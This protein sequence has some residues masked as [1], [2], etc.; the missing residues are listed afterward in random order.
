MK[1]R[2]T[3]FAF[4][5]LKPLN[6][7]SLLFPPHSAY[8]DYRC[9]THLYSTSRCS[10]PLLSREVK[11]ENK[12]SKEILKDLKNILRSCIVNTS[13]GWNVRRW[14]EICYIILKVKTQT[15]FIKLL[16]T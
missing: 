14:G 16:T 13:L 1:K 12:E 3:F 9:V 10:K 6:F 4:F 8:S 2:R 7:T 5:I 11:E 15:E